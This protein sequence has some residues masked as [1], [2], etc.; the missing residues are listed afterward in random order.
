MKNIRY[1]AAE[2]LL[3]PC[4]IV[5]AIV[6]FCLLPLLFIAYVVGDDEVKEYYREFFD[7]NND[8]NLFRDNNAFINCDVGSNIKIGHKIIRCDYCDE[9]ACQFSNKIARCNVHRI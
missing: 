1:Y 2:I 7:L 4:L 9:R 8:R 5:I 3:L 6:T